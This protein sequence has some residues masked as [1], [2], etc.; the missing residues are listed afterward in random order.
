TAGKKSRSDAKKF[1]RRL[2]PTHI[3]RAVVPDRF[4]SSFRAGHNRQ[5]WNRRFALHIGP[6]DISEEHSF[7]E[8]RHPEK[9]CTWNI[10][11]T[12]R[13]HGIQRADKQE[14]QAAARVPQPNAAIEI[15]MDESRDDTILCVKENDN[16][17]GGEKV[18][19]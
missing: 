6:N 16:P 18:R 11:S 5:N 3:L 10:R 19:R 12:L 7:A 17:Y 2:W 1:C 13:R 4:R 8:K 15:A 9:N 14:H